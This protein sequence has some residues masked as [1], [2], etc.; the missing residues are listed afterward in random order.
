MTLA[1]IVLFVYNRPSHTSKTLDALKLNELADESLLYIY[2]D[3]PKQNATED[4]LKKID[5]VRDI[6]RSKKW[7]K[8][9]NIIE[10]KK[11]KGLADSIINGVTEIVNQYGK[12]IVL[13]DDI[14]TSK[15]FLKYMNEAL[16]LYQNELQ[17]MHI[18]GYIFPVK[19]KLPTTFF[20]RQTSCWGWATWSDRWSFLNTCASELLDD[21]NNSG[22]IEYAD[23]DGTNQFLNQLNANIEGKIK[24]WAVLWHFSVFMSDG[25][26]LH[27]KNSLVKNIGHDG[28]G[29]H[30]SEN[31]FFN[32]KLVNYIKLK[33]IK[34]TDYRKIYKK[35]EEFYRPTIKINDAFQDDTT[36]YLVNIK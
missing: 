34:I 19:G 21:L 33:K 17:V 3:G 15:G 28:S 11:N 1:P 10:S 2:S 23:I 12:V 24:T 29:V 36:Y 27:P 20:Y 26:S 25:L 35:L 9:V 7:C 18:S 30:C 16:I 13:E 8:E 14:V 4:Q 22:K 6:I 31:K 32:S 5:E